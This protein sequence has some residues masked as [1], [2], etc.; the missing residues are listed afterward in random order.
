MSV[1]FSRCGRWGLALVFLALSAMPAAFAAESRGTAV[2][3][4]EPSL[5]QAL[6]GWRG[7]A[8]YRQEFRACPLI[9][10]SA[11]ASGEDFL[12]AWP[13]LLSLDADGKGARLRQNWRVDVENWIPLPGSH[14]YWPQEVR[15]NGEP[16]VVVDHDGPA[17]HLPP[18]QY[19][20]TAYIPW[21][22]RPQTLTVPEAVGLIELRID[23]KLVQPLQREGEELTLGRRADAG[24]ATTDNLELQVYRKLHD[25][26]PATLETRLHLHV[27]GKARE[28]S[29][30]PVLPEGFAPLVLSS[31][32]PAR[33]DAENRLQVQVQPGNAVLTLSARAN[34]P[35]KQV[36][37]YLP[38]SAGKEG[39]AAAEGAEKQKARIVWV[40]QE[41]WSY[42][43]TPSLR[44]TAV[45]GSADQGHEPALPVD[46]RQSGVPAEWQSLPAFALGNGAALTIEERAR[47]LAADENNRL[48]LRRELW[49]NFAGDGYFAR[50]NISGSMRHGWR[51]DV[52]VPY[53][54]E[55]ANDTLGGDPADSA[56]L[57]TY[58]KESRLTGVEWRS[59][60]VGLDAGVRIQNG[61]AVAVSRLPISGWQQTFDSV[62]TELH[63]PYGYRLL[64]APGADRA[65]GSW[66]ERWTVLHVFFAAFTTLLAWRLLGRGGGIVAAVYLLLA[67]QEPDAPLWALALACAFALL[68]RA[69]PAGRLGRV[70][71]GLR[72]VA[73]AV[74]ILLSI[75]FIPQQLRS[76]LYPQ[77]ESADGGALSWS[78]SGTAG[79]VATPP[80]AAAPAEPTMSMDDMREL[81]RSYPAS[82]PAKLEARVRSKIQSESEMPVAVATAPMQSQKNMNRYSQSTVVQTGRGEANWTHGHRYV[83][84]WSGP[85]LAEQDVALVISPP[86]LTR[87]LRVLLVAL[88][89]ILVWRLSRQRGA[90][91]PAG[92]G[93]AAPAAATT[94]CVGVFGLLLAAMTAWPGTAMART[95]AVMPP[96]DEPVVTQAAAGGTV[97]P[98]ETLLQEMQRRLGEA[99]RCTPDCAVFAGAEIRAAGN[100]IHVALEANAAAYVALPL[101]TGEDNLT[102]VEARLDGS[103]AS[104]LLRREDGVWIAL[105][106]GVHRIDLHYVVNG[107]SSSLYF[108]LVPMRARFAGQGWSVEGI[109]ENRLINETLN[110]TRA[111]TTPGE[112]EG[113]A[114]AGDAGATQ[115][116][117]PYVRVIRRL[118]LDLDWTSST[119]VLRLAPE[120]GGLTLSV[121]LLAGEHVTTPGIRVQDMQAIASLGSGDSV[122]WWSARLDKSET[123]T[124]TAPALTDRAEVWQV[125]VGPSWHVDWSGVPVGASA[126][127]GDDEQVFEFNPLPGET[128]TL[129]LT[130][131]PVADGMVQA[132][133]QVRLKS[134][135]GQR[136][137][138]YQLS[139]TLRASQGGEHSIALPGESF[140][141]L[142]VSRNNVPL[143]L[144]PRDGKLTLPVS[145]GSQNFVIELRQS[146]AIPVVFRNPAF[147]LGLPAANIDLETVLPEQRWLLAAFGPPVGSVV[148]FWGELLVAL[149]LAGL[150]ARS[151]FG[152]SCFA[153]RVRWYHWLLLTLGFSTYSWTALAVVVAWLLIFDWR[154]RADLG[155]LR[156]RHPWRFDLMQSA[157]ALLVVAALACLVSVI[158]ASL[159]GTPEMHVVGHGGYSSAGIRL[160]GFAD[161]SRDTLPGITVVSLPLWVYRVAMLAWAMWLAVTVI[162]WLRQSL[163]AWTQGGYWRPLRRKR[164]ATG[165][166]GKEADWREFPDDAR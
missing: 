151:R 135:L 97:F 74:L 7:W 111:A 76:A 144:R 4:A 80:P 2:Q 83:L 158:P 133:D 132:V 148:L 56:L 142:S 94:A 164:A 34:A 42:E 61:V 46:P 69:L 55:R 6:Q 58:G 145:P 89:G 8:M 78:G 118:D 126:P 154:T 136:A 68:V 112:G 99:P 139:F 123:L 162:G 37:A 62:T 28:V 93:G 138:V 64:A 110:F 155:A 11:G 47:G 119:Q 161:L 137:V 14:E 32:W 54:L 17:L 117:P 104:H 15:V 79:Y 149:A 159:M 101:P 130:Q 129:K 13:G 21:Q 82:P 125:R 16:G 127:A 88:L 72:L 70:C 67:M 30:G 51:F 114:S 113:G 143:S 65:S 18:G 60:R 27:S 44:S 124:L 25:G 66:I 22:E 108:P 73:L 81:S 122:T 1:F 19:D 87:G 134:N 53:A 105:A 107:A 50:D 39:E 57:V 23:G 45:R 103:A 92:G 48:A 120:K 24:A 150:L 20:I 29:L 121:P 165:K 77:L 106:R 10:G 152:R 147:S 96:P 90:T 157:L 75:A 35:L 86:W 41:I 59:A 49:L 115:Q 98:P 166:P 128:L 141:V 71:E 38:A 36:S 63:L 3:T 85:V 131:P 40:G 91:A 31:S 140:E 109:D 33:L 100:D 12:C 84:S 163:A 26:I 95:L 102:L 5:P 146:D 52:A 9:A 43:A 116:F 153:G 160:Q 156:E